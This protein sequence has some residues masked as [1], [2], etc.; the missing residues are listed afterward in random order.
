MNEIYI[1]ILLS[2]PPDESLRE[3]IIASLQHLPFTGF[4][5]NSDGIHAYVVK[6]LWSD[7]MQKEIESAITQYT[8]EEYVIASVREI[9]NHNWNAEWEKTI[10]PIRASEQ[11]IIEPSWNKASANDGIIHLVIEPKMSFGT[12]HHE[13]TRLM[14]RLL[15]R[16]CIP[17]AHVLDIG[18]GTGILSIAAIK[19]GAASAI[20]IDTDEW[21][22]KNAQDNVHL[23][24][25]ENFI[26]IKLGS[27]EIIEEAAFDL[28][29]ANITRTII[30]SLLDKITKQ[31]KQKGIVLL[32][33]FVGEDKEIVTNALIEARYETLETVRENEWLAIAAKKL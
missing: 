18:T 11:I 1:D 14:L 25:V 22:F 29:L 16:H 20:G 31:L 17:H 19:L 5:E 15:E 7:T 10:Q 3:I 6:E 12:G 27:I 32:S 13:T 28:I 23:N 26:E 4:F 24:N 33:G 9:Q 30:I 2:I 21:S 8:H